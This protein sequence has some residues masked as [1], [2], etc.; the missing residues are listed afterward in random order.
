MAN[1]NKHRGWLALI[2]SINSP[3]RLFALFA[4][5][6]EAFL[7]AAAALT[8]K[9]SM[10]APVVLLG[11]LIV[12]V[13]II[14][15]TGKSHV[16]YPPRKRVTVKI[17]FPIKSRDVSLNVEECWLV[18]RDETGRKKARVHPNC[19]RGIGLWTFQLPEDIINTDSARLELVDR[20]GRRWT[21]EPF[22]PYETEVKARR[23]RRNE[24]GF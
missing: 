18:I 3:L 17:I 2:N 9:L 12:C 4:L 24:Y 20:T 14:L 11:I 16:L 22:P 6:V 10:W 5:I 19:T 13:F 1:N 8:D 21:V 23:M 15:M 7:T